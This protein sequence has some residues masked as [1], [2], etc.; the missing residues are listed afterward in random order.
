MDNLRTA[1]PTKISMSFLS[2]SDN[3]GQGGL[4]YFSKSV[5]NFHIAHKTCWGAVLYL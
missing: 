2:F 5:D 3:L 1:W 4:N